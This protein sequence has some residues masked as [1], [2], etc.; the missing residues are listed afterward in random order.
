MDLFAELSRAADTLE[1]VLYDWDLRLLE[2]VDAFLAHDHP[3]LRREVE[4]LDDPE[5]WDLVRFIDRGAVD[6]WAGVSRMAEA[7]EERESRKN[8][9]EVLFKLEHYN[10]QM[11]PGRD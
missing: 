1:V 6:M 8:P 11:K 3:R 5:L 10:T 4:A 9:E 7:I 2:E